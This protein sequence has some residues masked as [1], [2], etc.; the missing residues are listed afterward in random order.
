M[1]QIDQMIPGRGLLLG[2]G[3]V[4]RAKEEMNHRD[5]ERIVHQLAFEPTGEGLFGVRRPK[6]RVESIRFSRAIDTRLGHIP[7]LLLGAYVRI[8][9]KFERLDASQVG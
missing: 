8:Q 5:N 2:E 6:K 3:R 4:L 1:D 9:L 7:I